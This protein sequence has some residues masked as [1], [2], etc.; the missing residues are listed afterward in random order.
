MSDAPAP[1]TPSRALEQPTPPE[2]AVRRALARARDGKTLDQGEAATLMHARGGHLAALL[3][4]AGRV[5]DAGLAAARRPAMTR[6]Q[7]SSFS[8]KLWAFSRCRPIS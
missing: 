8:R 1:R 3:A 5:R 7:C 2:S 4:H 6:G